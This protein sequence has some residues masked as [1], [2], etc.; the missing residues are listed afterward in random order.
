M[1][2]ANNTQEQQRRVDENTKQLNAYQAELRHR[3]EGLV[4]LVIT[5]AAG[6]LSLS[7]G[8]LPLLV[9]DDISKGAGRFL[10]NSWQGLIVCIACLL[11]C[12]FVL[13]LRDFMTGVHWSNNE[14]HELLARTGWDAWLPDL[15]IWIAGLAGLV[16]F[17]YGLANMAWAGATIIG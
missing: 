1:T 15:V 17:I 5:L 2:N 9:S 12:L 14:A 7:A 4:K 6:T 11:V 10:V 13:F 8:V 3:I 16:I